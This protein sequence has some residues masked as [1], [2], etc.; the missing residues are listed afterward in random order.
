MN[1]KLLNGL[2]SMDNVIN[3]NFVIVDTKWEGITTFASKWGS[4]R[5]KDNLPFNRVWVNSSIQIVS[6]WA[7][8]N[9]IITIILH[10]TQMAQVANLPKV[11]T[12]TIL[13]VGCDHLG[14]KRVHHSFCPCLASMMR[15]DCYWIGGCMSRTKYHYWML[16][17]EKRHPE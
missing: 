2:E 3:L 6:L 9:E 1:T 12:K 17:I 5:T 11:Q 4:R 13:D 7:R 8:T 14:P 10:T 15:S 16:W